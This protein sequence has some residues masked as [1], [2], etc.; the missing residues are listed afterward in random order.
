MRAIFTSAGSAAGAV[1]RFAPVLNSPTWM[2]R[3]ADGTLYVANSG[4]N[5]VEKIT[6]AGEVTPF[7]SGFTKL[8]GLA[9]DGKGNLYAADSGANLI[10]KITPAGAATIFASGIT[11]PMGLTFDAKGNLYAAANTG[12][13]SQLGVIAKVTPAGSVSNFVYFSNITPYALAFD[14]AGNLYASSGLGYS[15]SATVVKIR[16]NATFATFASGF[17]T[18]GGLAFDAAGNLYVADTG[19][20]DKVAPNGKA[21]TFTISFSPGGL[22]AASNDQLYASDGE[23]SIEIIELEKHSQTVAIAQTKADQLEQFLFASGVHSFGDV[24]CK[25]DDTM[26]IQN[27]YRTCAT[28]YFGGSG[29]YLRT[30]IGFDDGG[31]LPA[32]FCASSSFSTFIYMDSYSSNLFGVEVLSV[33]G[34]S[35][36]LLASSQ[37]AHTTAN[38]PVTLDL[39]T[40]SYGNPPSAIPS[41]NAVG[42]ALTGFPGTAITFSP[43]KNFTGIASFKFNLISGACASNQATAYIGVGNTLPVP[44]ITGLS[45][46]IG[47]HAG[48]EK[49]TIS[50]NNLLVTGVPSQVLFGATYAK[51]ISSSASQI[52]AQAPANFVGV[53]DIQVNTV[54]GLSAPTAVDKFTYK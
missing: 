22:L 34:P 5:V 19:A 39:T 54:G 36:A 24:T 52:V 33:N 42:G 2:A 43:K 27:N 50:G 53:I 48:G 26:D 21:A 23:S 18:A 37:I 41:G 47:P 45:P 16:P 30:D 1:A 6:P 32:L 28:E 40:N 3:A 51:V 7:A 25:Y 8:Q 49:I 9:L 20:I 10:K 38:T 17:T 4:N 12:G 46:S 14:A 15:A 35:P 44:V 29:D 31:N 11:G 13:S